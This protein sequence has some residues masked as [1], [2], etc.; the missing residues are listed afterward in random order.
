LS[1]NDATLEEQIVHVTSLWDCTAR[2]PSDIDPFP[3]L[4]A[5][6]LGEDNAI[7]PAPIEDATRP[8]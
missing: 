6:P 3:T 2:E 1:R 4:V 7:S 5:C 8:S